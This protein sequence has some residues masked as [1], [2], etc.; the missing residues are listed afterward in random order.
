MCVQTEAQSRFA[1]LRLDFQASLQVLFPS[2]SVEAEQVGQLFA[3]LRLSVKKLFYHDSYC[4][5]HVS[6]CV[7]SLQINWLELFIQKVQE[8]KSEAESSHSE[9]KTQNMFSRT[10]GLIPCSGL[11]FKR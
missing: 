10:P 7:F 1:S 11:F 4:C 8:S 2:V 3:C 6:V 5:R 9:V